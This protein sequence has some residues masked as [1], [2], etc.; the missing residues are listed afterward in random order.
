M[1]LEISEEITLERMNGWS[2][3]KNNTQLFVTGDRSKI[4]SC[5]EQYC[6]IAQE[7]ETRQIGS[8]QTGDG[9]SERQ[10][11]KMDWNG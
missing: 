3:S 11:T 10:R 7:H 2:Q 1:L 9:K 4:Q 5:K 8:S 6:N